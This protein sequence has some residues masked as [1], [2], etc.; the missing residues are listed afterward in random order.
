MKKQ[1]LGFLILSIGLGSLFFSCSKDEKTEQPVIET[2]AEVA[3]VAKP[4]P[5]KVTTPKPEKVKAVVKNTT[6]PTVYLLPKERYASEIGNII[7][8]HDMEMKEIFHSFKATDP[9]LKGT[10]IFMAT[11]APDGKVTTVTVKQSDLK[12]QGLERA[13]SNRIRLWTFSEVDQSTGN[14]KYDIKYSFV[15]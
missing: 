11:V 9:T 13:L 1:L 10:I 12:N 2:P 4:E 3:P 5:E 14:A 15:N 6:P 8:A 7:N